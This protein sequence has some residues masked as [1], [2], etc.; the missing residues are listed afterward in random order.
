MNQ[1][2][3][4]GLAWKLGRPMWWWGLYSWRMPLASDDRSIPWVGTRGRCGHGATAIAVTQEQKLQQQR[5]TK[6][7]QQSWI[8]GRCLV[9][10]CRIMSLF[11]LKPE[12]GM[13]TPNSQR[14]HGITDGSHACHRPPIYLSWSYSDQ[15]KDSSNRNGHPHCYSMVRNASPFLTINA[16]YCSD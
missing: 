11:D 13:Q 9:T 6:E 12:P 7:H 5:Q 1:W 14:H 3:W 10:A 8:S 16:H 2:T 4:A 15:W